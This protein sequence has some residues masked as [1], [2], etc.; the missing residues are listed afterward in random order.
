LRD[1]KED[2]GRD[3]E[4]GEFFDLM[5]QPVGRKAEDTRHRGY[6]LFDVLS[7]LDKQRVN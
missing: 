5:G 2:N 1:A 4:C 7:F 3:F 6:F